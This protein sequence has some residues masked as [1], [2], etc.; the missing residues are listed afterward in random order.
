M[1]TQVLRFLGRAALLAPRENLFTSLRSS[2]IGRALSDGGSDHTEEG[3][4]DKP[5]SSARFA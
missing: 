1:A 3:E 2:V 4:E 5:N